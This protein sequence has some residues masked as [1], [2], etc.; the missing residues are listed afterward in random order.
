MKVFRAVPQFNDFQYLL[1]ADSE[2]TGS[3]QFRF[4][5]T[6]IS[7]WRTLA[8]FSFK[9]KLMAGDFW[10]F[11]M[12]RST[13]A[14]TAPATEKLREFLVMAGQ[15]L[16][17]AF[18]SN[19]FSV[20]NVTECINC[21]DTTNTEWIHEKSSGRPIRIAK[22]AFHP[23]RMSES[24]IFK[25]P[26]TAKSEILCYEGLK[27]SA[28]EFKG[29]V[30]ANHMTGIRFEEVWPTDRSQSPFARKK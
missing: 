2:S 20:I 22:Y 19:E 12:L 16:P 7:D 25:I 21:L 17:V 18:E 4:D 15:F 24:S 10:G 28:D 14:T 27:D 6:P 13:W 29:F 5:C 30:E 1:L 9:P 23:D 3:D 8:V 26:E 11:E